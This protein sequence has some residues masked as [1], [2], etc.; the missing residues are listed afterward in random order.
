MNNAGGIFMERAEEQAVAEARAAELMHL[1]G[2]LTAGE[3]RRAGEW[4]RQNEA[5]D[6]AR[7]L[8]RRRLVHPV[9][10][11]IR[12]ALYPYQREVLAA[13]EGSPRL[14][15]KARQV[16]ISQ[17]LAGEALAQAKFRPGT[18][19]LFISRNLEAAQHLLRLVNDLLESDHNLPGLLKKNESEVAF[20]NRS[21]IRSLAASENAGRTY[22][23]SAVYL[24]EFAHCTWAQEIYQ[25]AAPTVARGGRLTIVSTPRG[26]N[27]LFYRLYEQALLERGRFRLFRLHWSECPEYNPA[28]WQ[29][30]E[31]AE[32]VRIGREGEWFQRQR[33]LYSEEQWA[34]EFECDFT[35]SVGLV[36]R[37]FD[38]QLHVGDYDYNP[39]W[40][41]YV[42]QDFGYTNPAVALFIQV[43]PA[44]EV[45]VFAEEYHRQ[46]PIAALVKEVYAPAAQRYNVQEWY[47]DPSGAGEIAE[48]RAAGVPA[49]ARRSEVAAGILAIR[50]LL[51]PADRSRPRLFISRRCRRLIGEL[52]SYAYRE[53]SET[54]EKDA[55][56]H[57]PD[58]LRYFV[59]ARF[60]A[61]PAVEGV[62]LRGA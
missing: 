6:F 57:G 2:R 5:P 55:S 48:L 21:I 30:P 12:F 32:R 59:S 7:Y 28:G 50:K 61:E 60:M 26:K 44:E 46:R 25:A 43:S 17:L 56:D 20:A 24:D 16:G 62:E 4:S 39:D 3:R 22:A 38:P 23:A 40:P 15:L 19:V 9:R 36:Y 58:A 45:Y 27:N 41:C 37:E 13:R 49:V 34:Q 10:G 42:G 35:S 8:E 52:S 51:R 33:P 11:R 1:W 29:A 31:E 18:L 47:C 14:I 54:P 53:G